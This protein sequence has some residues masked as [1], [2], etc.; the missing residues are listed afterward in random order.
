MKHIPFSFVA[1]AVTHG[2]YFSD[3]CMYAL[4][5]NT[6]FIV[7]KNNNKKKNYFH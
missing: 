4:Y 3:A 6:G 2:L 7:Q 1:V 5:K